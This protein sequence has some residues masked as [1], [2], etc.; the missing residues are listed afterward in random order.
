LSLFFLEVVPNIF[1]PPLLGF[2]I[3]FFFFFFRQNHKIR[4]YNYFQGNV[5]VISEIDSGLMKK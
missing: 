2:V 4:Y 5:C 1:F 3:T